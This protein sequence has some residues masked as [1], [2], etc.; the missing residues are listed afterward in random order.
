MTDHGTEFTS[1]PREGC[2]S[3]EP[4]EFQKTLAEYKIEHIKASVK[5]PQSNGKVEHFGHTLFQLKDAYGSWEAAVN[6]YNFKRPHWSLNI[7]D[8]ETPFQAFVRKMHPSKKTKFI[9]QH[10][11]LIEKFSPQFLTLSK[12]DAKEVV[13]T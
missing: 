5:H 1:L 4:N 11:Q 8:C 7:D 2:E 3:P 13:S 10:I 12:K 9:N 6:Y